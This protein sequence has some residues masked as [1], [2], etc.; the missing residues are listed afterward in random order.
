VASTYLGDWTYAQIHGECRSAYS[1]Y[2]RALDDRYRA[3][4]VANPKLAGSHP[5]LA[6]SFADALPPGLES[7]ADC[8][9]LAAR[10]RHHLSGKSSQALGLGLLGAAKRARPDLLWFEE[11]LAPVP[12]FPVTKVPTVSF[13]HE[14]DKT[15]LN[16]EPRV[17]AIDFFVETD[18]VAICTEIKWAEEGLGRCSCGAGRPEVA[19][20]AA[21]V[22]ARTRY[23]EAARDIFFLPERVPGTFCP[24]STGYQAIRNV[25]AA[26]ALS[27]D[28]QP[29]FVLLY[30]ENNP[31]FR[32]T[33]AWPGWPSV[34]ES[35]LATADS[36]G[37]L[38]F[39]AVSWQ[40][41][42]PHLP[43]PV[44][45]QQWAAEKHGFA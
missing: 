39:R 43:L 26:L 4:F 21:R 34:L 2:R 15:V 38:R 8:I 44:A 11:R 32:P 14:L 12:P 5:Q 10:H 28:R 18:D 1:G 7:L 42:V 17:T 40:Q 30:D 25:A 20:C 13:E 31:Y 35:T 36:N 45:V 24:I 33:N 19:D 29:V 16:E 22:L 6:A 23:W 27:G 41:L 37:L 3:Y 9:P